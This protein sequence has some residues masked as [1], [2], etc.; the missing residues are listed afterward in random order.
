MELLAEEFHDSLQLQHGLKPVNLSPKCDGCGSNFTMDH[1][2]SCKKGGLVLL[3]HNEV[4]A[5]WQQLWAQ[6]PTPSAVSDKPLIPQVRAK[7]SMMHKGIQPSHQT[8]V[9]MLLPVV[10]GNVVL[11]PSLTSKSQ[12]HMPCHITVKTDPRFWSNMRR[13]RS[14]SPNALPNARNS[15]VC[16]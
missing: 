3:Q 2:L 6:A 13:R 16:Y 1:A 5:E 14:I 10:F 4:A 8:I 12:T 7:D 9:D 11:W 15:P